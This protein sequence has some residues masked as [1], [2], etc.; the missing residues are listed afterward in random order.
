MDNMNVKQ[1][2]VD[3]FGKLLWLVIIIS[4]V[5]VGYCVYRLVIEG[6]SMV[7]TNGLIKEFDTIVEVK[8]VIDS[9]SVEL[10]NK[11]EKAIDNDYWYYTSFPLIDVDFSNLMEKNKDTVAWIQVKGT[12]INYPVVQTD[13]NSYY[14]T[15]AY[16]GKYNTGG[17]L[18]M[19]YRNNISSLEDRNTII[20]GHARIDGT[21]LGSLSRI[22][23]SSW[24]NNKDNYIVRLSTPTH[25]TMWQ[26]FSV[27]E[28]PV[29]MYYITTKFANDNDYSVFLDTMKSRSKYDF[30]T[31]VDINDKVLTLS[32]CNGNNKRVVLHAKLIKSDNK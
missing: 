32:T 30:N 1:K 21:M 17:W 20:Y 23:Y 7:E 19:D 22:F 24:V 5:V 18:F 28:T 16:D 2:K 4:A 9:D 25:N 29:E 8:E 10:V 13:N 6:I 3:L 31:D 12:N 26:V 15:H 27:Y 11:E 14:L